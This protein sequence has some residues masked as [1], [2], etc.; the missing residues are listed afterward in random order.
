MS[1]Q[2]NRSL[3]DLI[4]RGSIAGFINLGCMVFIILT[5]LQF[6]SLEYLALEIVLS[7]AV[8]YMSGSLIKEIKKNVNN[9]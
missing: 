5:F 6:K 8:S 1:K 4:L 2:N 3:L 7:G 9:K